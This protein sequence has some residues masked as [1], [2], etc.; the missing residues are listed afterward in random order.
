M[1]AIPSGSASLGD[2]RK[3]RGGEPPLAPPAGQ[4][5]MEMT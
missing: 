5:Q 3:V 4:V 2:G 1:E